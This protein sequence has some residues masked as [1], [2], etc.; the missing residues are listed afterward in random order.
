MKDALGDRMKE[1]YEDRTRFSLPRRTYTI[2][3]IDGR[4]FHTYTKNLRKPFDYELMEDFEDT[5]KALIQ[6]IQ[7]ARFAYHQS[8]EISVLVTDF[9]SDET[10]A[11]FDGNLQKIVSISASVATE[12]F[13][14]AR[15]RGADPRLTVQGLNF[16]AGAMFDARAFTI[17]DPVEVENYFIWRQKDATRNSM[18]MYARAFFSHKELEGKNFNQMHEMLLSKGENWNHLT[19]RVQRG[20]VIY[21]AEVDLAT[22]E[23]V[24]PSFQSGIKRTVIESVG[25]PDFTENREFLRLLIPEMRSFSK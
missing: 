4:A 23:V 14:R 19:S 20:Q 5:A 2:I 17:P 16:S 8:D 15:L 25:A 21:K 7:G 24:D 6:G 22:L 1:R 13:N 18:S 12:A 9:E 11:W 3:R 10:E